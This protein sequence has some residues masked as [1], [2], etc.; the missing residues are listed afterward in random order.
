MS[1][2]SIGCVMMLLDFCRFSDDFFF[3]HTFLTNCRSIS[4]DHQD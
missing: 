2:V 3:G 1:H 4:T